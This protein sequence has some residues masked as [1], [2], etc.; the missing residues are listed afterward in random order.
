MWSSLYEKRHGYA[1]FLH[2]AAFAF[3]FQ[4]ADPDFFN[5]AFRTTISVLNQS[6]PTETLASVKFRES[7]ASFGFG[8]L[9]R[10]T[11][12]SSAAREGGGE[13]ITISDIL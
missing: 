8:E 3:S 6:Q 7:W 11:V 10:V 5:P 4:A 12:A 1:A 13:P 9:V 2:D